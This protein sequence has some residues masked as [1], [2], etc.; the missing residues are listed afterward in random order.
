MA[1]FLS[2]IDFDVPLSLLQ[3]TYIISDMLD[4]TFQQQKPPVFCF[5]YAV[6]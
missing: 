6:S 1:M 3:T 5:L 2:F 4:I